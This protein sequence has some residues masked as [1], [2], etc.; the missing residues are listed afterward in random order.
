MPVKSFV[1]ILGKY[2]KADERSIWEQ[3]VKG[4]YDIL[5]INKYFM[6]I[7]R[8]K[9]ALK[10]LCNHKNVYIYISYIQ[11]SSKT[12]EIFDDKQWTG[13]NFRTFTTITNIH[14]IGKFALLKG[15]F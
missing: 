4:V 9:P 12:L 14:G 5:K 3:L 11:N 2:K 13:N 6:K 15:L 8:A 1:L 10:L 7:S